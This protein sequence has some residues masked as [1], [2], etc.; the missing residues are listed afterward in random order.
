MII[1]I[2]PL[3]NK[4]EI[5]QTAKMAVGV[6]PYIATHVRLTFWLYR[7][8]DSKLKNL[9][10]LIGV[11]E[12]LNYW[13]AVN[14]QG[15]IIGTI[16]LY[17]KASDSHNSVWMAYFCVDP[18]SRMQGVGRKLIEYAI[19][20]AKLLDVRYFNLYTST[21]KNESASHGLYNKYGFRIVK[22]KNKLFYK[23]LD[24]QLDFSFI[25]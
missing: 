16:G 9:L 4:E 22:T 5:K 25:A 13:V 2:I 12:Q 17:T 10:R 15:K 11:K 8:R 20:Q 14:E 7:N 1:K 6:F 23:V 18:E 21:L 24:M 3:V 19:E